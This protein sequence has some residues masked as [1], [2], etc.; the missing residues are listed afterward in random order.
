MKVAWSP[1][2]DADR[3]RWTC[4]LALARRVILASLRLP[5][6][7]S[8]AVEARGFWTR[9]DRTRPTRAAVERGQL[10]WHRRLSG[11]GVVRP[12][13]V[14]TRAGSAPLSWVCRRRWRTRTGWPNTSGW[15]RDLAESGRAGLLRP[16]TTPPA[17]L[18]PSWPPGWPTAR[19]GEGA[20]QRGAGGVPARW[21]ARRTVWPNRRARQATQALDDVKEKV[22]E[23]GRRAIWSTRDRRDDRAIT[24]ELTGARCRCHRAPSRPRCERKGIW[25]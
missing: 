11:R 15:C 24:P 10:D 17:S 13:A 21:T 3:V 19:P 14:V 23:D 16:G 8:A 25:A 6:S 22:G 12:H 7:T 2:T 4:V 1:S 18:P 9:V 20:G 5:P